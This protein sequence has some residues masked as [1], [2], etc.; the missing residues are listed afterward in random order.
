MR[1]ISLK[2]RR[3]SKRILLLACC[4]LVGSAVLAYLIVP[5]YLTARRQ[6]R[7]RREFEKIRAVG[8][9]EHG[10]L[11]L[12]FP[13]GGDD[14]RLQR[15]CDLAG[16]QLVRLQVARGPV[17][18]GGV[19]CLCELPRLESLDLSCCP[20]SDAALMD[21]ARITTLQ[22]IL[23]RNTSVS[24]R[25]VSELRHLSSLKRLVLSHTKVRGDS[26]AQL[27]GLARLEELVLEGCPVG[28]EGM[29]S[30]LKLSQLRT[31]CLSETQITGASVRR[32]RELPNLSVVTLCGTHTTREEIEQLRR[33]FPKLHVSYDSPP[34]RDAEAERPA[35]HKKEERQ[36]SKATLDSRSRRAAPER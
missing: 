19:A 34:E 10:R 25:G 24:D 9:F 31:L 6:E 35:E 33:D 32:L 20:I 18:D 1:P 4:A 8:V 7:L 28:D 36:P 17:T 15:V 30:V 16:E 11:F 3:P 21:L 14:E 27:A 12:G 23:V 22:E 2:R 5:R 13:D 26:L 29:L